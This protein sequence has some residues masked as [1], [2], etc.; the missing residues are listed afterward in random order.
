MPIASPR[1]QRLRELV[2]TR[3]ASLER[4]PAQLRLPRS[5]LTP[6]EKAHREK[7]TAARR[8]L[9]AAERKHASRVRTARRQ[10]R[11]AERAH[12]A[13]VRSARKALEKSERAAAAAVTDVEGR[14]ATVSSGRKLGTFGP[15]VVYEDRLDTGDEIVPLPPGFRALVG[16]PAALAPSGEP[17]DGDRVVDG[18]GKPRR[19]LDAKRVY[20]ALQDGDRRLLVEAR[21]EDAARAFAELVNLAALN[22]DRITRVRSEAGAELDTRLTQ[23]RREQTAVVD[24]AHAKLLAVQSD[25]EAIETATRALADTE[26]DTAEIERRREELAAVERAADEPTAE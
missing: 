3:E 13:A 12:D 16:P 14:L 5:E 19:H 24:Q 15:L 20:L 10:L 1:L 23:V 7:L 9:K 17:G 26:A 22:V 21:D 2:P 8:A 11:G 25:R 4:L 18:R 6:E